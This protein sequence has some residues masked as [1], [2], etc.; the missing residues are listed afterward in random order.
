MSA[1]HKLKI[2]PDF[3]KAVSAGEKKFE[4]R[5]NDRDFNVGDFLVLRE[6]AENAYTG[7]QAIFKITYILA[8]PEFLMP[9][10]VAFSIQHCCTSADLMEFYTIQEGSAQDNET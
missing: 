5:K 8:D 3:F 7:K 4:I 6:Y 10:Y 2:R 9:G 1:I